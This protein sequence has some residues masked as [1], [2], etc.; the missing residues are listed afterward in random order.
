MATTTSATSTS[1][2]TLSGLSSGLDTDSIVTQLMAIERMPEKQMQIKKSQSQARQQLLQDFSTKLKALKTAAA[3]LRDPGLWTA[4]QAVTSSDLTRVTA[5]MTSGAGVGGT[6]LQ[7][8][9]LASSQQRSYTYASRASD[10]TITFK[11]PVSGNAIGTPIA[12]T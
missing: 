7:V 10:D 4:K 2:M 3:A 1:P 11:D 9:R 8:D 5:V 6:T 12:I